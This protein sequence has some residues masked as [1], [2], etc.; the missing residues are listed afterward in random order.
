[1]ITVP[2]D[3]PLFVNNTIIPSECI[4]VEEDRLFEMLRNYVTN[5]SEYHACKRCQR[6]YP[7]PVAMELP[8]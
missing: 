7:L 3:T 4:L 1:M 8:S 5:A 2:E 6:S